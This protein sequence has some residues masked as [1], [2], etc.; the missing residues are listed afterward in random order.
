MF[1]LQRGYKGNILFTVKAADIY[2]NDGKAE[3]QREFNIP[4]PDPKPEK[5]TLGQNYPNPIVQGTS[6][7]YE[8]SESSSVIIEIYNSKGQLVRKIDAGYKSAGYY[9]VEDRAAYW[10]GKDEFGLPVSTGVY[11][12]YLKAGKSES[13]KKMAVKR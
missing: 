3:L 6:I 12:Y 4:P 11:F 1:K 5:F 9:V 10:D 13:V 2:D 7:P 8:L